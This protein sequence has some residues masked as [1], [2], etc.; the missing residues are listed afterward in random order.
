[1]SIPSSLNKI[2]S[3]LI[4][5]RQILLGGTSLL[6][7]EC[8]GK[9][10]ATTTLWDWNSQVSDSKWIRWL[11]FLALAILPVYGLFI[12]ADVLIINTIEFFKG[13]NPINGGHADLGNGHSIISSRTDDQDL[14][15]HDHYYN[16]KLVQTLFIRRFD[17]DNLAVLDSE[18]RPIAKVSKNRNGEVVLYDTM[19]RVLSTLSPDQFSNII[20]S[21]NHG[22]NPSAALRKEIDIESNCT[23]ATYRAQYAR[24]TESY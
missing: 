5:R 6:A 22:S 21:I 16:R 11:V 10:G 2:S 24:I 4:L 17:D 23:I 20:R 18:Q 13:D 15:R 9:F 19:G 12:L 1:M 3:H 7:T 8:W 14:I